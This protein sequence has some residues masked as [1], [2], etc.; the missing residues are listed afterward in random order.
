[1]NENLKN[2]A[3]EVLDKVDR[4]EEIGDYDLAI[5]QTAILARIKECQENEAKKNP[6]LAV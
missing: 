1:M 3:L 6:N 4:R 5:L 2:A